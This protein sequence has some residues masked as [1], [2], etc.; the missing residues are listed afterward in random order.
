MS[1]PLFSS[2]VTVTYG[3]RVVLRDLSIEIE[4]G[5]VLGLIGHSGCGKSTMA[6]AALNLVKFRG[7]RA[8][9]EVRL[10]GANLLEMSERQLRS[11]RGKTVAFVPQSP[12]SA[13]NPAL[14]LRTQF[15]EAWNAHSNIRGA[16][17]KA[18]IADSLCEAQLDDS[19]L[20]KKPGQI[21][22]G[23]AQRAVIAMSLLHQP[24]MIVADEPTSALDAINHE[25]IVSLFRRLS[26]E[27]GIGLL[28]ISHDLLSVISLCDR[29]AIMD[30]GEIVETGRTREVFEHPQH[31]LT[32]ALTRNRALLHAFA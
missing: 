26:S 22:V 8:T 10:E 24:R 16:E 25:E 28:Y 30:G 19:I 29:V 12:Q 6:L 20:D 18:R 9:G 23:M 14:K 31:P 27:R 1:N 17:M 3:E 13:L 2:R 7:G 21:S 4:A 5:E 15:A 32:A 11:M